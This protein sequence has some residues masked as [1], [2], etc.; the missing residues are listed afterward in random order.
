MTPACMLQ[1]PFAIRKIITELLLKNKLRNQKKYCRAQKEN[2]NFEFEIDEKEIVP[3][4]YPPHW[5]AKIEASWD[6]I[7]ALY[8][9][10]SKYE[11][12][13]LC[14]KLTDQHVHIK[15]LK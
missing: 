4:Y 2:R 15:F 11:E 9:L 6:H 8:K 13:R 10:A 1:Q 12:K 5:L 3:V 14:I 7:L